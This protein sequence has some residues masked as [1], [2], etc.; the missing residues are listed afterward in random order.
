MPAKLQEGIVKQVRWV[1]GE[2]PDWTGI[3]IYKEV[4]GLYSGPERIG[5]RKVQDIIAEVKKPTEGT[6]KPFQLVEWDPWDPKQKNPETSAFLLTLDAVC[7]AVQ[8]RHLHD[9]EAKWGKRLRVALQGIAPYD[10]LCFVSLY[11]QRQVVAFHLKEPEITADLDA[12]LAYKPWLPENAHAYGMATWAHLAPRPL[13]GS[14][15][16]ISVADSVKNF[17]VGRAWETLRVD[18]RPPWFIFPG[19][20]GPGSFLEYALDRSILSAEELVRHLKENTSLTDLQQ[21]ERM[22]QDT[23][24]QF[25]MGDNPIFEKPLLHGMWGLME[26][27]EIEV[28]EQ[29]NTHEEA[30]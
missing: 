19:G 7:Q 4:N 6:F 20:V 21:G 22:A 29:L 3:K 17:F 27:C 2:H 16:D 5:V 12:I 13:P 10:Q 14:R 30:P 11:A 26:P 8:D 25:W 9:H 15:Q 1:W 23:A 24:L 28:P 18:L